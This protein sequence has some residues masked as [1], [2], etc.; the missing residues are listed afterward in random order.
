MITAWA[1]RLGPCSR[2]S[3][4][5]TR[6]EAR[7]FLPSLAVHCSRSISQTAP[8]P[9]KETTSDPPILLAD[10]RQLG[11]ALNLFSTSPYSAGS[12][13][14][15]PDG[16][17]V[18]LKLQAFLRAH[19]RAFGFE[20]VISPVIYKRSLWEKSGHWENYKD[21]MFVVAGGG[22]AGVHE[23][24]E[25]GENEIYGLKAMNCP[26][27][28]LL[29]ASQRRSY[30][31]LPIRYADFGP[32]HRNEIS[33]ALSGLTRVR[34]FHQDDGHIFCLPSQ[35][36]EEI[37]KTLKFVGLVYEVFKLGP[38][39]LV[40]STRPE[41]SYIG[42]ED[43]W[44]HAEL[45]LQEALDNSGQEWQINKGDGAFYGPKID[46]ILKDKSGK[47]HQTAT[48][49]LDFQLPRRFDLS[50][51]HPSLTNSVEAG[52]TSPNASNADH[53]PVLIHRAILGSL[54]RF[55]ALLIEHY[56]GRWPFWLSPRQAIILT[57]N[58]TPSVLVHAKATRAQL[59]GH[60]PD[61]GTEALPLD[62][63]FYK[64]DLDARAEPLG[65]KIADA[66]TKRYN[67]VCTVGGKEAKDGTLSVDT[68]HLGADTREGL[69]GALGGQERWGEKRT[70]M[71]V[72]RL[73]EVMDWMSSRYL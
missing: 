67:L 15:H 72:R 69:R 49:Q 46:I 16:S 68:S 59:N 6:Y 64:V 44:N 37:R 27:H 8:T 56:N 51:D 26:G 4:K 21:D 66:K 20:E 31:E 52:T 41:Q 40:L 63:K 30:R 5:T 19:Y 45:H 12:P 22:V 70:V 35:I 33:G 28:C 47:E 29:Y 62:R 57:L 2:H 42:T 39:K 43:E 71:S 58:D 17:H 32:L 36:G 24:G 50:Y 13:L 25:N 60:Q 54:E 3:C 55:M 23:G 61:P 1:A 53:P 38:F 34:R 14:L 10:H 9:V 65:V 48:I 73:E 11:T 7:T 18:F